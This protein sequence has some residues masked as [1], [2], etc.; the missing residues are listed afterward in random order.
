M[1]NR[2]KFDDSRLDTPSQDAM[3][4]LVSNLPEESLSMAWRSSL[5]EKLLAEAAPARK[6][7]GYLWFLRPVVAVAAGAAMI[8]LYMVQETAPPG[9]VAESSMERSLVQDHRQNLAILDIVGAGLNPL[10][11]TPTG[12][13]SVDEPDW[14]DYDL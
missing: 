11:S 9:P 8:S 4:K 7:R 6:R 1:S 5:N 12:S 2:Q 10:E 13:Y 3:R 14:L